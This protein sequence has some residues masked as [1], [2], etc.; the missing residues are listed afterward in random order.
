MPFAKAFSYK[1]FAVEEVIVPKYT[2]SVFPAVPEHDIKTIGTQLLLVANENVPEQAIKRIL[3]V[4]FETRF[5]REVNFNHLNEENLFGTLEFP[6][7]NGAS[8]F[9]NRNQP[10]ITS[11]VIEGLEN[12]RSFVFSFFI[13]AFLAWRWYLSQRSLSLDVY[14]KKISRI[15]SKAE[16]LMK[17]EYDRFAFQ[18]LLEQIQ[19]VKNDGLKKVLDFNI[20]NEN[21]LNAFVFH[22]HDAKT[23]IIQMME[24]NEQN[25]GFHAN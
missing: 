5:A 18:D 24:R 7:H 1:N 8:L 20:K 9:K 17:Q 21:M 25:Q 4:I 12:F 6:L 3:H 10:A 14:I 22:V 23:T 19:V 11:D 2:Y 15:E 13:A 16:E